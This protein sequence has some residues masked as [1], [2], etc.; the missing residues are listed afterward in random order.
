MKLIVVL[1]F[2]VTG[3]PSVATAL[4]FFP[5]ACR[6]RLPDITSASS[7]KTEWS[8]SPMPSLHLETE[9]SYGD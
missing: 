1:R 5:I 6:R 4:P 2:S 3:C 8:E 9:R 7:S